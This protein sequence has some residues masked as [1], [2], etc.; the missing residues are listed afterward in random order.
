MEESEGDDVLELSCCFY[1]DDLY[2]A[3]TA[4]GSGTTVGPIS[5]D[6]ISEKLDFGDT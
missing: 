1:D 2:G 4:F 3:L 5:A 6:S